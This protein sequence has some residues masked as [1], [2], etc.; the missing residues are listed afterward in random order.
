MRIPLPKMM[1]HWRER[2]FEKGLNPTTQRWG[3]G[4]WAWFA[5]RPKLYGRFAS[6]AIKM[7]AIFGGRSGRLST[8][9]MAGGWTKYR[10]LPAP[11][12]QTFLQMWRAQKGEAQ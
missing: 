9:P 11:Q 1:R 8:L 3:L 6:M 10:D 4:I 5:K 7:L 2:E 12:G